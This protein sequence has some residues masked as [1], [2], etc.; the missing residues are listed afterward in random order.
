MITLLYLDIETEKL[1]PIATSLWGPVNSVNECCSI[2]VFLLAAVAI[3][4]DLLTPRSI[5]ERLCGYRDFLCF[6]NW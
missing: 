1:L 6:P 4:L 5:T 3:F 2:A